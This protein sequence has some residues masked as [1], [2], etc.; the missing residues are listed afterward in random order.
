MRTIFAASLLLVGLPALANHEVTHRFESSV[1]AAAVRRI[2]V[3]IPAGEVTIR[4]GSS[5]TIRVTGSSKREY[6]G[7]QRQESNQKIVDDVSADIYVNR[8]EAV[9]RRRFGANA[10][11]W[12]A[13]HFT[14]FAMSIEVPAGTTVDLQTTYGEVSLDGTFGDVSVDLRAGEIHLTTPRAAVRELNASCRVGEV[15]TNLGSETIDREGIFPGRTHF[16][17]ASGHS[18]IN[19]H[20]TAGEVHVTLTR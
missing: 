1:P 18:R 3:D 5:D 20:T 15:H 13:E 11:G 17:N 12:R 19:V 4:N 6:D 8:E 14:T 10:Q 9:I 2:I 16:E 7:W